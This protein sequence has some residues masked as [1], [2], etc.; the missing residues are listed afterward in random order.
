MFKFFVYDYDLF[1]SS[2]QLIHRKCFV[3]ELQ[4]VLIKCRTLIPKHDK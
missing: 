1:L 4:E 2:V 3:N